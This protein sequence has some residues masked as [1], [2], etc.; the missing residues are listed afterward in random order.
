MIILVTVEVNECLSNP[1]KYGK[2]IDLLAS[3]KCVCN[4]GFTGIRC[5]NGKSD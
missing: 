2:C 5:Q 3:Y 1:C 4:R